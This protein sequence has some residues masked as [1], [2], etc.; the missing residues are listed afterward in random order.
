MKLLASLLSMV[1]HRE[2]LYS[3]LSVGAPTVLPNHV[4]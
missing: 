4:S 3:Q 2:N 1:L